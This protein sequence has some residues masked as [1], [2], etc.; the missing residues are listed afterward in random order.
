MKNGDRYSMSK[1]LLKAKD[2]AARLSISMSA[3]Y[4]VRSKL[5]AKG[6]KHTTI[7]GSTKYLESSLEKLIQTA[8]DN[9]RPLV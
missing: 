3:F 9:E 4:R 1:Q 8:V 7:G 6:L 2:V 5:L